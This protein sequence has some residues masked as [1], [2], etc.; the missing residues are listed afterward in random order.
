MRFL[1]YSQQSKRRNFKH[2]NLTIANR[3][4]KSLSR[5]SG[6]VPV[7]TDPAVADIQN[8]RAECCAAQKI[9]KRQSKSTSKVAIQKATQQLCFVLFHKTSC[10]QVTQGSATDKTRAV[11]N[12]RRLQDVHSRDSELPEVFRSR[13][14][15]ILSKHET[16]TTES[17]HSPPDARNTSITPL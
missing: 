14:K 1:H 8:N 11:G 4:T 10:R 7:R 3:N 2:R 5:Y 12:E 15:A 16:D 6:A 17:N 9:D 13:D